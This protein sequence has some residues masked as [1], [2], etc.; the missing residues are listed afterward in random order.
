MKEPPDVDV[1]IKLIHGGLTNVAT[2]I[3]IGARYESIPFAG[4]TGAFDRKLGGWMTR[5]ADL[6]IIS[7]SLGHLFTIDVAQ[8]LATSDIK[9][10]TL[11]LAGLGEPARFAQDGLRFVVSNVFTTVKT[12]GEDKFAT[13]LLGTRR[14]EMSVADAL[15]GFLLGIMDGYDRLLAFADVVPGDRDALL[16]AASRP[17]DLLLVHADEE[18]GKA[19]GNELN[20]L[21]RDRSIQRLNLT[22]TRGKP[23]DPDEAPEKDNAN[24][25]PIDP[26]VGFMRVTRSKSSE[27]SSPSGKG[28]ADRL[29]YETFQFSAL[30]ERAVVPQRDVDVTTRLLNDMAER[31]TQRASA[32]EGDHSRLGCYFA[33]TVVPDDF[34]RLLEGPASLT[35]EVDEASA[36]Y[37]WEMIAQ[38]R[39]SKTSFVSHDIALSRQFRSLLSPP[40]TSPPPLNNRLKILIIADPATGLLSLPGARREALAIVDVLEKAR[41]GWQGIYDIQAEVRIGSSV[42]EQAKQ[43]AKALNGKGDWLNARVCDPL[44]LAMLIVN[45]Q[46][47]IIHYAGHGVAEQSSGL[48]GWLL[49]SDCVLSARDIFRVRQ[50]PRLVFANACFT[51]RTSDYNEMR[52]QMT[53]LAQAFFARGIGNFVGAGWA[54]DDACAE[55]CARW[56]YARLF[57]LRS[58]DA[59]ICDSATATIGDALRRARERAYQYD[60]MS[61]SWGAYQHYGNPN[62]RLVAYQSPPS[63]GGRRGSQSGRRA[64]AAKADGGASTGAAAGVRPT[65][66]S[67]SAA[68]PAS[69]AQPERDLV[70]V[71]GIDFETGQYAV[72]PQPVEDVARLIFKAP[73]VGT[74]DETRDGT[75]SFAAPFGIDFERPS[76]AGWG[77]VFHPQ[78]PQDVR[79]ALAPLIEH[80]RLQAAGSVQEL[81]FRPGEQT[82]EWYARH[83]VSPGTVDPSRVPY[84]LL[85]VG[86]PELIPF[87]FQYL[88]CIDY[89]VGRLA[90][91]TAAEYRQYVNSLISYET[92][93]AVPNAREIVY[94]GTRHPNDPATDLSATMLIDPLANGM[95]GGGLLQTPVH[96]DPKVNFKP[97]LLAANSATKA[98]LL[99]VLHQARPPAF[100]FTASHGVQL[101]SGQTAQ[102]ATQGAL[103]CQDWTGF[104]SMKPAHVLAAA[105]VADDARVH[106]V[107]AMIF[108]CF[109]AGTPDNDQFLKDLST[110]GSAPTLAPKPFVSALP[111]RLLTHPNGSALAVIGH[112]DRAWGYS[113]R[114][115]KTAGPQILTFRNSIGYMLSGAPVGHTLSNQFSARF[116][117]LSTLLLNATSPTTPAALRLPDKDLVSAWIERND[118]QNY[119][120]LGDPA[121]RIRAEA[122]V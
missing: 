74:F 70:Y 38:A 84:Y 63:G 87:E 92:T 97:R 73:R 72:P 65:V 119:V 68:G 54:V 81:E 121:V 33:N 120:L 98:N 75:Q 76:E 103:L 9:A 111:R 42:D 113:I 30:S 24:A 10:K 118:A 80:R 37:P 48:N 32:Q 114:T 47:D 22:V 101:N 115:P 67:P 100:V 23:V 99:G 64:R 104:G 102:A 8:Y 50:V 43:I 57:G 51:S 14:K 39:F 18:Q 29:P 3:A 52:R 79:D 13:T 49:S 11:I 15:R 89:A 12:M 86:G 55:E 40:Q 94:W 108:A 28:S 35:I 36:N 53:G 21:I 82:R 26:P 83:N 7:S 16:R 112:V 85:L 58:P 4:S 31:L 2:P 61:S 116:T 69:A 25:A 90:F 6:G 109:G 105:D 27:R 60:P 62:D 77:V 110:A 106:G 41:I 1:R 96:A 93:K 91:D 5:A 107:V 34:R 88:L 17:L 117:A 56:F 59:A 20:A 44:E 45:D 71:N 19:I 78:T 66:Q 95:A 46:Q 122:L